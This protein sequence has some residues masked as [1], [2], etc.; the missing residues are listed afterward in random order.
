MLIVNLFGN[1]SEI[2]IKQ[3]KSIYQTQS[4]QLLSKINNIRNSMHEELINEV[5]NYISLYAP[6]SRLKAEYL[7][8]VCYKYELDIKFVLA[9][10]L[11]ESH[12][13][14]RGIAAKTNS[15]WNIGTYDNGIILFTYKNPNESIEPYAILLT[16][17]YLIDKELLAL[18]QDKGFKNINGKRFASHNKYEEKLRKIIIQIDMETSINLY[19]SVINLSDKEI[20][21]YFLPDE[22]KINYLQLY[23]LN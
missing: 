22:D 14:T 4:E 11:L 16:E 6:T 10:A 20:I 12:F 13:G 15:V 19:Q 8:D 18:A 23:A 7:V 3:T 2:S 1:S 9:Q 17:K 5:N 21:A